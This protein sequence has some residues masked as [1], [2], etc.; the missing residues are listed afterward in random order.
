MFVKHARALAFVVVA[1]AARAA[2]QESR[3]AEPRPSPPPNADLIE[4]QTRSAEEQAR[5]FGELT[6]KLL[7]QTLTPT[8]VPAKTFQQSV[9]ENPALVLGFAGAIGA[10]LFTALV[11]LLTLFVN[12]RAT[13]RS[14]SD[15]QFY[16]TVKLF[17]EVSPTLRS[18][19]VGLLGQMTNQEVREL[20]KLELMRRTRLLRQ[21]R[22]YFD[23]GHIHLIFGLLKEEDVFALLQLRR[24]LILIAEKNPD[25]MSTMLVNGNARLQSEV[26]KFVAEF[27]I[28]N[29]AESHDRLGA[30]LWSKVPQH[31]FKHHV[32]KHLIRDAGGFAATFA[33]KLLEADAVPLKER[34]KHQAACYKNLSLASYRL[35]LFVDV[36]CQ[37]MT[38]S[39]KVAAVQR[40]HSLFLANAGLESANL[41]GA[42]LRQAYLAGAKLRGAWM[43]GAQMQGA[44]LG[45][46]DLAGA[47]LAGAKIDRKTDLQG[48]AWWKADF[49]FDGANKLIDSVLL[50]EI[51]GAHSREFP[52]S[53]DETH[54]SVRKFINE[55]LL[56][57]VQPS[58]F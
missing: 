1:F 2:A 47:R 38:K 45:G 52:S 16:D 9:S 46:A 26:G 14:K 18:S 29:G 42:N 12:H 4:A 15:T 53:L 6:N 58:L 54:P 11:G 27:M 43:Q 33:G 20:P 23:A 22:P 32:Y 10:A 19:A 48:A 31:V 56:R 51:Y 34:K 8:P 50:R 41:T 21:E 17:G 5:F 37:A 44:W 30:E 3:P 35:Y 7:A 25:G 49:Y 57:G 13:I 36:Y 28:A 39:L 24:A 40:N 55:E